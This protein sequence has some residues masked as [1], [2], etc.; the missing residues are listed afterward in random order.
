MCSMLQSRATQGFLSSG[1]VYGRHI[2]K[3]SPQ[4]TVLLFGARAGNRTQRLHYR[5]C[6]FN[7]E[8]R[9]FLQTVR[10]N[11]RAKFGR[12]LGIEPGMSLSLAC[13]PSCETS[14]QPYRTCIANQTVSSPDSTASPLVVHTCGPVTPSTGKRRRKRK[15]W[16]QATKTARAL[17]RPTA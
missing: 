10:V 15:G 6:M 5:E 9:T 12:R 14:L 3:N 1:A 2:L 8:P 7:H 13:S 16:R 17:F 11:L 4:L